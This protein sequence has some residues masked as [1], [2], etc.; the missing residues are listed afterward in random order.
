MRNCKQNN[1]L[2]ILVIG[3][4]AII[5]SS[6]VKVKVSGPSSYEMKEALLESYLFKSIKRFYPYGI[7]K[8]SKEIY[9]VLKKP[10]IAEIEKEYKE[11][12]SLLVGLH[13][14]KLAKTKIGP[15]SKNIDLTV[16]NENLTMA[17]VDKHNHIVIDLK[18]VQALFRGTLIDSFKNR[19]DSSIGVLVDTSEV[20]Q[21]DKNWEQEL[22][23]RL[24]ER[25]KIIENTPS[26]ILVIDMLNSTSTWFDF[27]EIS[28]ASIYI[29]E[30]FLGV[31]LFLLAHELGHIAFD[32]V[33]K[34]EVY[35]KAGNK[36]LC[37]FKYKAEL[38]ADAYA[39]ILLSFFEELFFPFTDRSYS[40]AGYE[41]F[42]RDTYNVAGFTQNGY[43]CPYPSKDIRIKFARKVDN[44]MIEKRGI[45]SFDRLKKQMFEHYDS[46]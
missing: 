25:I 24:L 44:Y 1:Y 20:D 9:P 7:D 19:K 22:I 33:N 31:T 32:H 15:I 18:I 26:N 42:F 14:E 5:I 29:Q 45:I 27:A 17:H 6:C 37:S 36:K 12:L 40:T 3:L 35:E 10:Q 4:L 30:G 13:N 43:G 28:S 46:M 38:I 39:V 11:Y 41:T 16:T 34:I 23:G 2:K 21:M 8:N